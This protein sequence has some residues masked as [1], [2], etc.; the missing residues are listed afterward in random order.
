MNLE[1]KLKDFENA[2]NVKGKGPL[3][4]VLIITRKAKTLTFPIGASDLKSKQRGQVSGLGRAGVQKILKEYGIT[5][6]L[7]QEGG[8]T[9]RG[10]IGL[11]E[12]YVSFLNELYRSRELNLDY[13]ENWW[14]QLI[15]GFFARKPLRLQSDPSK[16]I[17]EGINDLLAQAEKRQKEMPGSTYKGALMQYL[18]GAKLTLISKEVVSHHGFTVADEVSSRPGDYFLGDSV[19]HVTVVPSQLL[20]QK[21][22]DNLKSGLK[23][24][25][26]TTQAGLSSGH[27]LAKEVN[28][29]D[30][31]D[32]FEIEQFM[33]LNLYEKSGF[34]KAKHSITL[35]KLVEA[36]NKIIEDH[37]TDKSLR[38]EP[39]R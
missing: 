11:M 20:L 18:V 12:D 31:I 33:A 8:R 16:S 34:S 23:P 27:E 39:I 29:Q 2:H 7:A 14:V 32:I 30:K 6:V 28:I 37:E 19:I 36:Y 3:S 35:R 25:I 21:C 5:R 1:D 10:S 13:I 9:S 22:N 26:I 38:I 17:R 4:A 15:A 24:I